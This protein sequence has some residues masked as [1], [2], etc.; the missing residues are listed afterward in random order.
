MKK[1][2]KKAPTI[3]FR[4]FTDDWEQRKL[5]ELSYKV[6][7]KNIRRQ[8]VE[9]LTNSAEY[10]I[11]GQKDYFN[12]NISNM[13]NIDGY[14]IVENNDFIYNPRISTLAPFGPINRNKL[15][16]AGIISPLYTVFN[17]H[18]VDVCYLEWFFKSTYWHKFMYFNGDTGARADRFSIKDTS[19]FNMPISTPSIDEQK[20]IGDYFADLDNLITL[21]QRKL[22]Q[23]KKLKKYFLQNMF[24]AKGEKVPKIRFKGFTGD[25][26][27]RKLKDIAESYSGGTPSVGQKKYYEGNIPFI[28]SAEINSDSTELFLSEEGLKNSSAKTVAEGDILYALYGATSGEVGRARLNGAINQAILAIQPHAEFD[29]E[30][31]MQWLRKSKQPIISK[32]LQGGQGNLSGTIVTGLEIDLPTYSEQKRIGE[33]FQHIDTLIT[34]HQQKLNQ[35]QMM[36]KFMLQNLFI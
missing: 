5:G 19:F 35:L 31:I 6:T 30:F 27:Q 24:P 9:T 26:E 21:H 18:D 13:E 32:Y 11:I 7:T 36:K 10:G 25:W 20:K 8:Y 12:H 15:G 28:R 29:S 14:Y 16:R 22:D 4:G 3:R 23:L 17:P 1:E 2:T 34:L 33:Y